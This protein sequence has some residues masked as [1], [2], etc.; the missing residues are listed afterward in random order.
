MM[1]KPVQNIP[2]SEKMHNS[3][4]WAKGHEIEILATWLFGHEDP[5]VRKFLRKLSRYSFDAAI[6]MYG[7]PSGDEPEDE[8]DIIAEIIS[9]FSAKID[10]LRIDLPDDH[11]EQGGG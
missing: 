5:A 8:N 10:E 2:T 11:T 3:P 9:R 6:K 1:Q 4:E 7:K